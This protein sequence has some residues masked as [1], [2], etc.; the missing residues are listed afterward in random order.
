V[1]YQ[2]IIITVPG[3]VPQ[4][5]GNEGEWTDVRPWRRKALWQVFWGQDRFQEGKQHH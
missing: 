4:R 1:I 3:R 5:G 2:S